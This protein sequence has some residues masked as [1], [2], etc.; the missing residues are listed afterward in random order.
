MPSQSSNQMIPSGFL[1]RV[2]YKASG[3]MWEFSKIGLTPCSAR[4]AATVRDLPQPPGPATNK[5]V[6]APCTK[7]LTWWANNRW[8]SSNRV[9]GRGSLG[10]A[11]VGWGCSVGWKY[12]RMRFVKSIRVL[13]RAASIADRFRARPHRCDCETTIKG[14]IKNSVLILALMRWK[15]GSSHRITVS[16]SI[17]REKTAPDWVFGRDNRSSPP[18]CP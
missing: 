9:V 12:R 4:V 18:P 7:I 1:Q 3:V 13:N 5:P 14:Q 16:F 17:R 8:R 15:M 6:A 11:G 2:W 10:R